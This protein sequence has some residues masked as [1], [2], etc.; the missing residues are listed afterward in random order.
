MGQGV[1][2]QAQR[3]DWSG[4]DSV[5]DRA[6][7]ALPPDG[8]LLFSAADLENCLL[9]TDFG[10]QF[11][12]RARSKR[13]RLDPLG[14]RAAKRVRVLRGAVPGTIPPS[15]GPAVRLMASEILEHGFFPARRPSFAGIAPFAPK[16]PSVDSRSRYATAR[17]GSRFRN[18]PD[19]TSDR[20]SSVCSTERPNTER[21][22]LGCSSC[23]ETS[24]EFWVS[25]NPTPYDLIAIDGLHT[26]EQAIRDLLSSMRFSHPCTIWLIDD[27]LPC[28]VFSAIPDRERSFRERPSRAC[29]GT[30]TCPGSCSP[31][32]IS[33]RS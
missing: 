12:I 16:T 2:Y 11:M 22:A 1:V 31:S 26:F 30:A 21:S 19:T 14:L 7:A 4:Y 28:D 17:A 20:P 23:R 5:F 6:Q 18:P 33:S 13:G 15:A 27:T 29:R 25:G 8:I 3:G 10:T 9:D 24:D 32:M